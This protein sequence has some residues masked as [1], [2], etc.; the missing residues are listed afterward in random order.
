MYNG[1]KCIGFQTGLASIFLLI[2]WLINEL[3]ESKY[4]IGTLN[5]RNQQE[6]FQ[7][8]GMCSEI[9]SIPIEMC[10]GEYNPPSC[11]TNKIACYMSSNHK[12]YNLNCL[13]DIALMMP[14]Y[15]F[16]FYKYT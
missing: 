12:W 11:D 15:Q 16:Y 2:K 9:I 7:L 13:V 4:I 3:T 5:E 8:F 6:V 10:I 14:D 1:C